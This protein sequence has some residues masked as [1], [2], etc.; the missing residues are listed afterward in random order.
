LERIQIASN[1][2]V[3]LADAAVSVLVIIACPDSA[4]V[5]AAEVDVFEAWFV[6]LLDEIFSGRR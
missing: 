2:T 5:N 6:D 3:S 4:P 1:H